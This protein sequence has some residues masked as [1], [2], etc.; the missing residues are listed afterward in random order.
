MSKYIE[1]ITEPLI[2]VMNRAASATDHRLVGYAANVDF[3]VAEI[4]HCVAVMDSFESR[5]ESFLLAVERAAT[6]VREAKIYAAKRQGAIVNP[7][8]LLYGESPTTIQ[9]E[10]H[11]EK[12]SRC[13]A[14]LVESAKR[15]LGR[16]RNEELIALD[17]WQTIT[18]E[19]PFLK[20]A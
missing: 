16:L 20:Q 2:D 18:A 14:R 1:A 15:F 8:Q 9:R 11:L 19:L 6:K 13:R 7:T 10:N 3:W 12:V 4:I 17:K 5:Q